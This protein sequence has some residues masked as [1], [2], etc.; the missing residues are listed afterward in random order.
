MSDKVR[1]MIVSPTFGEYVFDAVLSS[2]HSYSVN[3]TS[4]PVQRGSSISDHAF[5]NPDSLQMSIMASDVNAAS[6]EEN[7]SVNVFAKLRSIME[8]CEPVRIIT[9]LRSYEDMMLTSMSTT[10][11][12]RTMYAVKCELQFQHIEIVDVVAIDIQGQLKS[13]K[14]DSKPSEATDENTDEHKSAIVK[15]GE[16]GT[17]VTSTVINTVFGG[18]SNLFGGGKQKSNVSDLIGVGGGE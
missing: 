11:D 6:A 8:M 16:S 18:I 1:T 10:D 14:S 13:G 4:H 2:S 7:Y 12:F 15:S 5:L 9:R 17:G 3:I